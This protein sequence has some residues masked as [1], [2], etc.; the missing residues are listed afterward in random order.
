MYGLSVRWSLADADP[1]L[2][3]TLRD[4]VVEESIARFSGM[5][6]LRMKTWRMRPG[7]WF[8]GTYVW[9]TA[10]ARDDFAAAF[11]QAAATSKVTVLIGSGPVVIE[12]HE[13][14][15]VVE[16]GSGFATGGGPGQG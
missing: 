12:P 6:G 13:V 11:E 7:E 15:A 14:V 5:A 16:G 9:E 3:T 1:G 10:Q 2:A 4:Y 8:E